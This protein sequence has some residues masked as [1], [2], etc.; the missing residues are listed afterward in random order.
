MK[1]YLVDSLQII[2]GNEIRSYHGC[3]KKKKKAAKMIRDLLSSDLQHFDILR[4]FTCVHI[5]GM[6]IPEIK[7]IMEEGYIQYER[8]DKST[9]IYNILEF[10]VE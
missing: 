10:E 3:Y 4:I 9:C 6:R 2:N 7:E 8:F 1:L 5:Y